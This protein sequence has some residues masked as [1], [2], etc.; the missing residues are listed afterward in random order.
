MY[1]HQAQVQIDLI[2]YLFQVQKNLLAV[3]RNELK[4]Y[5]HLEL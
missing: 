2:L 5:K 3:H 4:M 1:Y